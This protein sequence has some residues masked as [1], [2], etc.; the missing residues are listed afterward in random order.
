MY[1]LLMVKYGELGLK[2]KNKS[3]FINKLVIFSGL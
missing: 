1:K 3:I 2:G